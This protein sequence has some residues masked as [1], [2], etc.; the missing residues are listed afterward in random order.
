MTALFRNFLSIRKKYM[1]VSSDTLK[2]DKDFFYYDIIVGL[3][4]AI[5]IISNIASTKIIE[6][7][8]FTFDGGTLLF[9]SPISMETY[10]QKSMA[11]G[12]RRGSYG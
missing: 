1:P 4:V 10:S 5:L 2:K 9:P 6:L 12:E 3:F 7:W 11:T 8:R